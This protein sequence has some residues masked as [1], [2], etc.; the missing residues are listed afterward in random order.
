MSTQGFKSTLEVDLLTSLASAAAFGALFHLSIL[1]NAEV[2]VYMYHFL[3]L[4]TVV[5][6]GLGFTYLSITAFTLSQTLIRLTSVATAFYAGVTF[7]IGTYRLFFHRL[8]NF[9]G[10]LGAKLSRFYTV[11]KA[12][13]NVQSV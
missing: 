8:R 3:T 13:K 12:S 7:S 2:D 1:R 6:I 11:R 5:I 4:S 9:P 10:P